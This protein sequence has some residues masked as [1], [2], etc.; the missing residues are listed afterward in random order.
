MEKMYH[1]NNNHKKVVTVS[2]LGKVDFR[3]RNI[4]REKELFHSDKRVN[5]SRGHTILY[6]YASSTRASKHLKQKLIEL[7]RRQIYNYS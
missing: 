4:T 5:S 6:V 2:I 7:K 3:T 1:A